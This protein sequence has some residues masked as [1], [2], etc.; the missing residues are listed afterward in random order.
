VQAKLELEWSPEQIAAWLRRAYPGK[1]GWHVW[2]ETIYQAVYHGGKSGLNRQLSALLRT[3]RPLRKPPQRQEPADPVHRPGRADRRPARDRAAPAAGRRLGRDLI[4]GR[5]NQPA[6]GTLVDQASRYVRL[7][8]LP[9]GHDADAVRDG[10]LAIL[11]G[12]PETVRLS[13]TW[14]QGSEMA[15]HDQLAPLLADDVFFAHPASPWQ[16]GTNENTNGLLRRCFRKGSDLSRHSRAVVS[17]Q[18]PPTSWLMAS[19]WTSTASTKLT[20]WCL[21]CPVHP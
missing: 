19:G 12:L 14:D 17:I 18:L 7:V 2:H 11:T 1:P 10:M 6:I 15:C 4:T 13:L 20:A 3:G 16:R 5:S 9:A 8:H 21:L